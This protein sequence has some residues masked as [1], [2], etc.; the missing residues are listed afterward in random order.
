MECHCRH[1]QRHHY[2]LVAHVGTTVS[3]VAPEVAARV[4]GGHRVDDG[5]GAIAEALWWCQHHRD[6]RRPFQHLQSVAR[7]RSATTDVGNH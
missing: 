7:C 2:C 3:V 1:R 5:G 6:H 4:A